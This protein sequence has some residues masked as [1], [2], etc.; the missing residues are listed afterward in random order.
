M[1]LIEILEIVFEHSL[2]LKDQ[3]KGRQA[4]FSCCDLSNATF[5]EYDLSWANFVGA[6]L[7]NAYFRNVNLEGAR[8]MGACLDRASFAVSSLRDANFYT[9]SLIGTL[10]Y[11]CDITGA[12]WFNSTRVNIRIKN[13]LLTE[14]KEDFMREAVSCPTNLEIIRDALLAGSI[15]GVVS[16]QDYSSFAS[17]RRLLT[18]ECHAANPPSPRARFF[19]GIAFGDRPC[20]NQFAEM[21]LLWTNEAITLRDKVAA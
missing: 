20:N 10:F 9:S 14:I 15:G 16:T 11:G 1:Q 18:E 12:Q 3:S 6:N 7:K 2:W 17:V 19:S 4:D 21:A 5:E 8:F 13:A